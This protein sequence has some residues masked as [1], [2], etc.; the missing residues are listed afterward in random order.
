MQKTWLYQYRP[1]ALFNQVAT[2][3]YKTEF[4]LA[5]G[6]LLNTRSSTGSFLSAIVNFL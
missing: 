4:L 5:Q 3:K 6:P 2:K 1:I